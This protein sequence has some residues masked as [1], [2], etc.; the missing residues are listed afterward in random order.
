MRWGKTK[1]LI[2]FFKGHP[3]KNDGKGHNFQVFQKIFNGD[4]L[5]KWQKSLWP[6][7]QIDSK[8]CIL[9]IKIA[10]LRFRYRYEHKLF[11]DY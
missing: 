4:F 3:Q 9:Q 2:F 8:C 5:S 1:F 7:L 10:N 11:L 6:D